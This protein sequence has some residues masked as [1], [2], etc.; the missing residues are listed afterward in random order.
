MNSMKLLMK[1]EFASHAHLG[2]LPMIMANVY[3]QYVQSMNSSR[4]MD[5]AQNVKTIPFHQ[6]IKSNALLHHVKAMRKLE[7]T[8]KINSH[9]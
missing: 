7:E 3:H 5:Y 4:K 6:R 2:K 9:H 8:L 1:M